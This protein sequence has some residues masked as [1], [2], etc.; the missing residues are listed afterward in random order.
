MPLMQRSD[1][2]RRTVYRFSLYLRALQRMEGVETVSSRTLAQVAGVKP[3]QLRKDLAY[4]KPMGCRGRG[5]DVAHL[6]G[7]LADVLG[8]A[9]PQGVILVGVGNLG[10]ALVRYQGFR[11]E[12][13]EMVAGFD[14]DVKR[15]RRADLGLVLYPMSELRSFV[16]ERG[17]RMAILTVP[18]A[19]AQAAADELVAAGVLAILNFA[20][21]TLQVPPGVVVNDVDLAI[22][23]ENLSYF[24]Q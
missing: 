5:Y 11:K 24:I 7:V 17:V 6:T 9:R 15:E 12:G 1:V 10:A 8:S 14:I 4:L 22:E 16:Q 13:F 19:V 21:A 23:L 2:P 18:G 3:P 20:P